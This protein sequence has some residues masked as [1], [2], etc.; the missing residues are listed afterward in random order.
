MAL[1]TS[2]QNLI[3]HLSLT[4]N[5]LFAWQLSIEGKLY[6]LV[7]LYPIAIDNYITFI[8]HHN[9]HHQTLSEFYPRLSLSPPTA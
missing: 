7:G 6:L 1:V 9:Q 4:P 5:L 2:L 3:P 8:D